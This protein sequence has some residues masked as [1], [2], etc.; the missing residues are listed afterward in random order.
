MS[1]VLGR[2]PD[3][4]CVWDVGKDKIGRYNSLSRDPK[5]DHVALV[6]L[7]YEVLVDPSMDPSMMNEAAVD[8]RILLEKKELIQG[9]NLDGTWE[10]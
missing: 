4:G 2:Q 10:F 1:C 6:R 5:E 9:C 8:L 7:F 3:R